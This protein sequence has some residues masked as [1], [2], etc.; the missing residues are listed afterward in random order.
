MQ[1]LA[2]P[3]IMD[4][5]AQEVGGDWGQDWFDQQQPAPVQQEEALPS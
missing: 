4:H 2:N 5:G 1:R 3:D